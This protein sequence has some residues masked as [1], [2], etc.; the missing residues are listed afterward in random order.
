MTFKPT[1]I[2]VTLDSVNAA[3]YFSYYLLFYFSTILVTVV[4][5][6]DVVL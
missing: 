1:L 6:I 4:I 3:V 2:I 5:S